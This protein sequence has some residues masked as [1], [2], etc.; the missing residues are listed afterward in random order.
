MPVL[1]A[2]STEAAMVGARIAATAWAIRSIL[3]DSHLCEGGE[4]PPLTSMSG[5]SAV[6]GDKAASLVLI[7]HWTGGTR[8]LLFSK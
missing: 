4:G 6:P 7:C 8:G 2:F 1:T 5:A 3:S